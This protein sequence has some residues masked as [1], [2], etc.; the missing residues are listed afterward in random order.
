M[1]P[2]TQGWTIG[3]LQVDFLIHLPLPRVDINRPLCLRGFSLGKIFA[4]ASLDLNTLSL[5]HKQTPRDTLQCHSTFDSLPFTSELAT[6]QQ[7]TLA[8]VLD[9][10][11]PRISPKH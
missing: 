5:S 2:Y 11:L 1:K 8:I 6:F 9:L 7:G 10:E 4:S 3:K